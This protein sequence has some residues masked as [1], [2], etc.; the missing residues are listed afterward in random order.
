MKNTDEVTHY[1]RKNREPKKAVIYVRGKSEAEQKVFCHFYA[2][3]NDIEVLF[4]TNNIDEVINCK[5][6]DMVLVINHSR[7]SRDT[8]EYQQIV[9]TL[10]EK[11]IKIVSV[12]TPES[13]GRFIDL[14]TR[15]LEKKLNNKKEE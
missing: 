3:D 4:D 2:I 14:V 6:C 13:V 1:I 10:E 8:F 12:T 5:D 15:N 7:I 11:G 9:N